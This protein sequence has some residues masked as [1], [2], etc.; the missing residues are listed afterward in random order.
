M[1]CTIGRA[2]RQCLAI[3]HV[4]CRCPNLIVPLLHSGEEE[5][6]SYFLSLSSSIP[7]VHSSSYLS[8]LFWIY[9]G[10]QP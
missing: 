8:P 10:G 3:G 7:T 1:E 5:I 9:F 4:Q 6:L 2:D